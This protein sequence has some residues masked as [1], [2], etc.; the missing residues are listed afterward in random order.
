MSKRKAAKAKES[1]NNFGDYAVNGEGHMQ[2][3]TKVNWGKSDFVNF[4]ELCIKLG[5]QMEF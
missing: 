3:V 1:A 2:K 4:N 5:L